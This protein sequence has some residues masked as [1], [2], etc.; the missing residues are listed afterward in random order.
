MWKLIG[1][2]MRCCRMNE[3]NYRWEFQYE[4]VMNIF[5]KKKRKEKEDEDDED[6]EED[7][8]RKKSI[9]ASLLLFFFL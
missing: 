1:W 6:D 4:A 9:R 8:K 3:E 5:W 2:F 7:G